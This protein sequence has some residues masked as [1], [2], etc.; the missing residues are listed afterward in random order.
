MMISLIEFPL[1]VLSCLRSGL[2]MKVRVIARFQHFFATHIRLIAA[3][4]ASD[5]LL[6]SHK[7]KCVRKTQRTNASGHILF[8]LAWFLQSLRHH[9]LVTS[10]I[11]KR[12]GL[13]IALLVCC[14][15]AVYGFEQK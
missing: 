10:A 2:P 12:A 13:F 1:A 14:S 4:N 9:V 11:A 7:E 8:P 5:P 15:H 6:T 3:I